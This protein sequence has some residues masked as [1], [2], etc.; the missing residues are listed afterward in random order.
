MTERLSAEK[1][2]LLRLSTIEIFPAIA[3]Q[4]KTSTLGRAEPNQTY[5][6]GEARA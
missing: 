5:D 4:A 2:L 6:G 1:P 3:S